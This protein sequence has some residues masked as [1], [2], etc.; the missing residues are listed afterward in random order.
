MTYPDWSEISGGH[1][2]KGRDIPML[3]PDMPTFMG[4]PRARDQALGKAWISSS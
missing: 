1:R 2:I 3:A 4:L